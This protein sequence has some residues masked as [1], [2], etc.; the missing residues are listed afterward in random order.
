MHAVADDL[1]E[2]ER[3]VDALADQAAV[4]VRDR[5]HDRLDAPGLDLAG[6][7]GEVESAALA[8]RAH[9]PSAGSSSGSTG[10]NN[11]SCGGSASAS[12]GIG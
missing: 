7:F 8:Q 6:E 1:V 12:T 10:R 3:R 2:E 9:E 11:E 5:R 4:E